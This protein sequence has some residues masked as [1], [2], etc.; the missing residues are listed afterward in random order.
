MAPGMCRARLSIGIGSTVT[1]H[2]VYGKIKTR[3]KEG[4]YKKRT[5]DNVQDKFGSFEVLCR[6]MNGHLG[7]KPGVGVNI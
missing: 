4:I 5:P 6:W 3:L 1:M 2:G 7:S